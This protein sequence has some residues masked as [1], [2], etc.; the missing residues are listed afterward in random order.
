MS[1]PATAPR[2]LIISE[3]AFLKH[4]DTVHQALT[5]FKGVIAVPNIVHAAIKPVLYDL[6]DATARSLPFH[7]FP[8]L[9]I[10]SLFRTAST[11]TQHSFYILLL[12]AFPVKY[13]MLWTNFAP[14]SQSSIPPRTIAALLVWLPASLM[15]LLDLP[16]CVVFLVLLPCVGNALWYT[17]YFSLCFKCTSYLFLGK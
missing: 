6:I 17:F 2:A 5:T 8:L 7:H 9:I 13:K 12:K 3:T 1:S 11:V 10:L 4:V 14:N 16:P 15:Q